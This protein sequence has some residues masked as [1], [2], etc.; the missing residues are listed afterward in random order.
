[1][2]YAGGRY[3]NIEINK[4]REIECSNGP[5]LFTSQKDGSNADKHTIRRHKGYASAVFQKE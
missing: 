2:V 1:M 4:E 3:I 5:R